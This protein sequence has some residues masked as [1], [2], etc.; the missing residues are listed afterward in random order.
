[1]SRLVFLRHAHSNA[2]H[3]GILSGRLPGVSLS[4][5]G[6][7]QSSSLVNRLSRA[8]FD[9]I[10]IS[11]LERCHQTITP[12]LNSPYG[13]GALQLFIDDDLNE[14]DYGSWSGKKLST[15]RKHQLWKD[16]QSRPHEVRF[17]DGERMQ[18]VYKRVA[19]SISAAHSS[20]KS[21]TFLFISH[22]DIIKTALA[23]AVGLPLRNFQNFVINPA[24]LSVVDFD[25]S[26]GR[27]LCYNDNSS[28][29]LD[30]LKG[31][32]VSRTLVGGGA[33]FVRKLRK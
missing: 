2:N 10:R 33:G 20:K 18:N 22:G 27:L 29:I 5:K 1:M 26:A 19:R 13:N 14:V 21:G 16:V 11:P 6:F 12:W 17:P 28:E 9:Q 23:Y 32:K 4:V 30:Y 24:S 3:E 8:T 7:E 15:L 25:G 31:E